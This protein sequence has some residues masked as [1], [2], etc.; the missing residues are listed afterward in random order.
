MRIL[1]VVLT[2]RHSG[3]EM[4]AAT[5]AVAHLDGDSVKTG[6]LGL[7][8]VDERFATLW[9][10]L[11]GKG[12]WCASPERPPGRLAR[13]SW[14]IS[15]LR[16]FK[17]DVV[18]AHSVIP[19]AY[20]RIAMK[21]AIS[22]AATVTVLHAATNDDYAG[23]R[24]RFSER[25]L[26]RFTA[27]VVTVTGAAAENYRRRCGSPKRLL[28]IPNGIDIP[29]FRF[30]AQLRHRCRAELGV[31]DGTRVVLQV[32]RIA[33]VKNQAA[34]VSAIA[35][36]VRA[37]NDVELWLAGLTEDAA[38]EQSLRQSAAAIG[39]R[40][41]VRFLGSRTDIV[42]LLSAADVYVMPSQREAHSVA[43]IEALAS[44][45]P[46]VASAIPEFQ[47]ARA[48]AG[49]VTID[50]SDQP[51]YA[52][53]VACAAAESP[54]RHVRD[55]AS[56]SIASVAARYAS[57]FRAVGPARTDQETVQRAETTS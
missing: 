51:Y 56:F 9:R 3:A 28:T 8:P 35:R 26:R 11:A 39:V 17:P 29:R 48:F 40:S 6:I 19:A 18:V 10:S 16:E 49:V 44:G 21:F 15:A 46:V 5:L 45:V 23:R 36:L 13:I 47:F 27:A 42:S 37:G 53:A 34:S 33:P 41:A 31:A 4:L 38:Y 25:W 30:D 50:P 52:E 7:N 24:L 22:R 54:I 14:I 20:A 57:L 1:H 2:P 55:L 43:M 12:V 32:G